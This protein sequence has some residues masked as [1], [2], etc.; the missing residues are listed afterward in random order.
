[1][2]AVLILL[3]LAMWVLAILWLG[4]IFAAFVKRAIFAAMRVVATLVKPDRFARAAAA[5]GDFHAVRGNGLFSSLC[6]PLVRRHV[7]AGS[8][9][10]VYLDILSLLLLALG[11]KVVHKAIPVHLAP[12]IQLP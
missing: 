4:A 1:M 7:S 2:E 11:G 6:K 5:L 9:L 3:A 12:I 10:C 8:R